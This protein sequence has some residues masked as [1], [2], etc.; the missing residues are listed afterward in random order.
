MEGRSRML[1]IVLVIFIEHICSPSFLS[2]QSPHFR[3]HISPENYKPQ[4]LIQDSQGIIWLGGDQGLMQFDGV[5]WER[6]P[7]PDSLKDIAVSTI[8]EAGER[9]W[10]GY[11]DG[12]ICT[13]E[14]NKLH[15]F[16]PEEGLPVVPIKGMIQDLDSVLWIGTYGEGLYYW[17]NSR[18]YNINT[19]DGLPD[20]FIYD[21]IMDE[22]GHIWAA[23]D[24]GIG[25][26]KLQEN[27]KIIRTLDK[28]HGLSDDIVTT[29][30]KDQEGAIWIGTYEG[31][32]CKYLAEQGN[33]KCVSNWEYGSI[34][35]LLPLQN[36]ILIGTNN[37]GR[38]KM[39][40][41][42]V[43]PPL[44][45]KKKSRILQLYQDSE[46]NIWQIDQQNGLQSAHSS[47]SFLDPYPQAVKALHYSQTNMLFFYNEEGLMQFDPL[48]G[49]YTPIPTPNGLDV[50]SIYLDESGSIW[51]GT[52]GQGAWRKGPTQQNFS[53]YTEKDGLIN[54]NVLSIDGK[55]GEVWFATF[56]GASRFILSSAGEIE[57]IQNFSEKDGLGINYIYRVYLDSKG[58][59][60]FA[61]DGKGI[62]W[63]EQGEINNFESLEGLTFYGIT[64]DLTGRIWFSCADTG[65]YYYENNV[66]HNFSVSPNHEYSSVLGIAAYSPDELISIQ[67]DGIDIIHPNSNSISRLGKEAGL[68]NMGNGLNV[69]SNGANGTIWIGSEQGILKYQPSHIATGPNPKS[70]IK[71]VMVYLEAVG[72]PFKT[73]FDYDQNHI[74]FDYIGLWYRN[75]QAVKY[76]FRL[77][78]Q[79]EDWISSQDTRAI[80]P[81]LPPGQYTF[82][83]RSSVEGNFEHLPIV[84][85]SF[86][87]FPPFWKTWWFALILLVSFSTILFFWIKY[88]EE[89]LKRAER[90]EKD[91]IISEFEILKN[92][93][94]PH[95]LFNSFNTLVSTIEES[96]D[97]AVSYVERLSDFFRNIL[98]VREQN[99]ITLGEELDLLENFY[100]LQKHRYGDN[101]RLITQIPPKAL[102]KKVAPLTLQLLVENAIKHNIVSNKRPLTVEIF[103]SQDGYLSVRNNLQ[104][105]RDR[106]PSTHIGLTNIQNRYRLLSDRKVEIHQNDDYFQVDIPLQIYKEI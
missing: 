23:T 64:E 48:Q 46:G 56:G 7:R 19:D 14:A 20:N 58:R 90:I 94:N 105:R 18:L 61:T 5:N 9:L 26:C 79:H 98:E 104:L 10:I 52:L 103:L 41:W 44:D 81:S 34:N 40:N 25:I 84:E 85:Y 99:I 29:F 59:A 66:L 83:L 71:N 17:K 89:Q 21:I 32:L 102:N 2:A 16:D 43:Q 74:S 37:Y 42:H 55:A 63:W 47:I 54:D 97:K 106:K 68:P 36:E 86:Q 77:K 101:F 28:S 88:R 73:A 51:L 78:G 30:A 27:E 8:Y 65:Y 67:K 69:I 6:Y 76:Q 38:V 1:F 70:H 80:Y 49:I 93:I 33:F 50:T 35:T 87:I 96:P 22:E 100:Q 92:Q 45:D 95:F 13:L 12:K 39:Q 82:Q 57:Q 53:P 4:L 11:E 60:W 31:G 91:K 75:P 62:R 15:L 3:N 24:R 72:V